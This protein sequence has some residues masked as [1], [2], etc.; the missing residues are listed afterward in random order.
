MANA[1]RPRPGG[2]HDRP[3]LGEFLVASG[4]ITQ[5]QL[6]LALREQSSWGGRLGQNLLD[7]GL[8]DETTLATA[9]ARQLYLKVVDLDR[10]PPPDE[11]VRLVPVSIAE[12]Y[13][14]VAIA[15]DRPRGKILVACFDPTA[16]DGMREVR[17]TT[18]LVPT[19]CVATASQIERATR[20]GYYGERDPAPAPAPDLDVTRGAVSEV[21][22]GDRR[23]QGLEQ[24][25]DRL[26]D[27]VEKSRS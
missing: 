15:V 25:I 24:R 26:L 10:N 6:T 3:R 5:D 23:L 19:A 1:P 18:G 8:I 21:P 12:R 17:R 20:R 7:Q 11:V 27:L 22:E 14:L 13:G 9:I 4:Y 2:V 16:N